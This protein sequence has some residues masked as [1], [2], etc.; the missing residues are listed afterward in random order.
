MVTGNLFHTRKQ[1]WPPDNYINKNTI[2]LLGFDGGAPP[3]HAWRRRLNSHA[4]ILKE[5]SIT[6]KEAVKM[7]RLGVR[8][9]S[10]VREEASHGR[11]APID[12][13][14]RVTCKPSASQGVPLGGMGSGSISRGF[15]GDFKH[16]QIIPSSCEMSPVMANQFSVIFFILNLLAYV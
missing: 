7:V 4:N 10:Y 1:S 8:L 13:F 12:P 2:Y 5:F 14:T 16:F 9:W 3:E 11:K 6:F 15:R